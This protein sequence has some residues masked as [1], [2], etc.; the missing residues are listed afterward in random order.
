MRKLNNSEKI[1]AAAIGAMLILLALK[2]FVLGP[3]Y[4]KTGIYSGEIEQAK[5][6]IRKYMA[7]EHNRTEILKAQKQ[8]EGYSSLKGSDED[9][10]AM[11][12]SKLEAE[13]RRSKL[14]ILDMNSAGVTKVKGGVTL[15]RINLNAEGQLKDF[16]DFIA[17]IEGANILLQVEKITLAVKDETTG[18]LKID[19]VI[20]GVAFA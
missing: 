18:L 8:I 16:L 10:S 19:V 15:Y 6:T 12:M 2:I 9:K 17:G 13:A 5:L 4:D 20:L 11:V 1:L 3:I 14:Q 7:L